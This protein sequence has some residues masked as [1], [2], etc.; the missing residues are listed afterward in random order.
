[1]IDIFQHLL[2]KQLIGKSR[3]LST[4]TFNK[5]NI[6]KKDHMVWKQVIVD[7]HDQSCKDELINPLKEHSLTAISIMNRHFPIK[8]VINTKIG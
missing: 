2:T 4:D 5:I 1:M 7:L 6:L 3:T 8:N